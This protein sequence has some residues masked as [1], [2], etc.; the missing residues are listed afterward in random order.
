MPEGA[1]DQ[2]QRPFTGLQFPRCGRLLH[3]ESSQAALT[4]HSLGFADP[5]SVHRLA[6]L[7]KR[8][9]SHQPALVP[10]QFLLQQ[11]PLRSASHRHKPLTFL[12]LGVPS[13]GS[14]ELTIPP[15]D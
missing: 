4:T 3:W 12:V 11:F 5:E 7:L 10:G 13:N 8:N 9:A 6:R 14:M 1:E 15:H 2:D